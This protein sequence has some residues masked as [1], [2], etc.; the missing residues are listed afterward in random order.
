MTGVEKGFE[1]PRL[2]DEHLAAWSKAQRADVTHFDAR[3]VEDEATLE[4]L[5]MGEVDHDSSAAKTSALEGLE[6]PSPGSGSGA[7]PSCMRSISFAFNRHFSPS[8]SKRCANF[9]FL[10]LNHLPD[11][12]DDSLLAF[13]EGNRN[14]VE[15]Q[16][17]W[18][19]Q[20][21]ESALQKIPEYCP[22]LKSL[23]LAGCMKLSDVALAAISAA[24]YYARSLEHLD[25]TRCPKIT[26]RSVRKVTRRLN[27]LRV[28]R[29]YAA[30]A[31]SAEA[32][33]LSSMPNLELLDACGTA[34]EDRNFEALARAY[35]HDSKEQH[36]RLKVL[37]LTWCTLITDA[38]IAALCQSAVRDLAE[39][40]LFGNLNIS[41][42]SLRLLGQKFGHSLHT[43]DINGCTNIPNRAPEDVLRYLPN[44]TRFVVHT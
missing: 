29:V 35:P 6:E 19:P 17:Y 26:S 3:F 39:L 13:L 11:L 42:E 30:A 33:E 38:G 32:F 40:S 9:H 12:N 7:S 22:Y 5:I 23:S 44:V 21:T 1:K 14:L 31:L 34:I 10:D 28:L 37:N 8:W 25:L 41:E 20:L 24:P 18:N 15:L 2:G 36:L 16:L 4:R 43:L 27:S